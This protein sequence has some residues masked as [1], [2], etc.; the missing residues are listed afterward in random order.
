MIPDRATQASLISVRKRWIQVIPIALPTVAPP[1]I[2]KSFL[3]SRV[4]SSFNLE[5]KTIKPAAN[6][7]LK[8]TSPTVLLYHFAYDIS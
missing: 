8:I 1:N 3:F 2:N 4:R 7:T 5:R 6:I